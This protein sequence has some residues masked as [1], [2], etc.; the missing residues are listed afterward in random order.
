MS[1][2]ITGL[3]GGSIAYL[4]ASWV[5]KVGRGKKRKRDFDLLSE[6]LADQGFHKWTYVDIVVYI[7]LVAITGFLF[8]A[9]QYFIYDLSIPSETVYDGS[10]GVALIVLS[11]MFF[12]MCA[13]AG[14]WAPWCKL[15]HKERYRK[16]MLYSMANQGYDFFLIN[17][18]F[19]Y[20]F[21]LLT[22]VAGLTGTR[23][24]N[25]IIEDQL[26]KSDY[27]EIAA[28]TYN[29]RDIEDFV[30]TDKLIAPNGNIVPKVRVV[31]KFSDGYVWESTAMDDSFT[32]QDLTELVR[33]IVQHTSVQPQ[34]VEFSPYD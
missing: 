10:D 21:C 28:S 13:P 31:L 32:Q 23:V 4:L 24:Y 18:Y 8:F 15:I 9:I 33:H 19:I 7:L 30:I 22:I 20:P 5:S 6:K 27:L 25:Y 1:S 34:A 2:I 11:S 26:V 12:G 3:I 14:L 17:R 29:L 16:Y